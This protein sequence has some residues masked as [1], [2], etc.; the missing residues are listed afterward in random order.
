MM[1]RKTLLTLGVTLVLAA[2][3]LADTYIV[4]RAHSEASFQVRHILT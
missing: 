1:L 2:P 3:A 4:D